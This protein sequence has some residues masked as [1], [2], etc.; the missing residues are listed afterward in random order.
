MRYLTGF[1]HNYFLLP[2]K[3]TQKSTG[4]GGLIL[5]GTQTGEGIAEKMTCHMDLKDIQT[6]D[7][8]R[9]TITG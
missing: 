9:T 5:S 6:F 4:E 2:S 7:K 1:L 8:K 3:P